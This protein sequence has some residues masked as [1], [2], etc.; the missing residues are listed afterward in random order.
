MV[1]SIGARRLFPIW[2]DGWLWLLLEEKGVDAI[3]PSHPERPVVVWL[4]SLLAPTVDAF[5][6]NAF[7]AQ[8]IL[9]P[10]FALQS[11]LLW[12]RLFPR[13]RG[14]AGMVALIAIAPFA[15][16]VQ[17]LTANVALASLLSVI[18]AYLGVLLA[19]RFVESS[20]D[21]AY[22]LLLSSAA[23]IT[24]GVLLQEYGVAVSAA[25]T[26][27]LAYQW[28]QLTDVGMKRRCL[29]AATSMVGVALG[30]YWLY[31]RIADFDSPDAR[32]L[33]NP[34]HFPSLGQ[35]LVGLWEVLPVS[36]YRGLVGGFADAA[37]RL[38][39]VRSGLVVVIAVGVAVS[40]LAT[41]GGFRSSQRDT[42]CSEWGPRAAWFALLLASIAALAPPIVAGEF[43][44]SPNDGM[45]SRFGLPA[46]PILAILLVYLVT[47][48]PAVRI[49][50]ALFA[51]IG[52]VAAGVAVADVQQ[53]V[54]EAE[55]VARL[56]AC[57]QET[58]AASDQITVAVVPSSIRSLGPVSQWELTARLA[59]DFPKGLSERLWAYRDG[60]GPSRHY[61]DT[62][63]EAFGPRE[64]CRRHDVRVHVRN[65]H[66]VGPMRRLLWVDE[67]EAGGVILESYCRR[68]PN[69]VAFRK[70]CPG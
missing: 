6:R 46:Q 70:S 68:H 3:V 45:T 22:A 16:Q 50:W 28:S 41:Y 38:V 58:V 64:W 37:V 2:D 9:W 65:L 61:R 24:A 15:T 62:A 42:S 31:L 55:L 5:W 67:T 66:R 35:V 14:Y 8:A 20:N 26:V 51:A 59:Q 17:M 39:E 34:E 19:L 23:A 10:V 30:S 48:I 12:R 4:W 52:F 27:L 25:G 33:L 57:L 32:Q 60:G 11:A 47:R 69:R 44:W 40:L 1:F 49:R 29:I 54:D 56:G 13:H 18:L 21:K 53:G 43:P 63:R 36:L 7:L